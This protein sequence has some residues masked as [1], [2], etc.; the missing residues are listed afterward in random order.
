MRQVL[1]SRAVAQTDDKLISSQVTQLVLFV[2]AKYQSVVRNGQFVGEYL[3][4]AGSAWLNTYT[5]VTN[6]VYF[7]GVCSSSVILKVSVI[8]WSIR[9]SNTSAIL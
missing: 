1:T 8:I 9:S 6:A 4:E 5:E 2:C 7:N 3:H